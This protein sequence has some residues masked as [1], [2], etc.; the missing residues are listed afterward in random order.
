MGRSTGTVYY[1]LEF[2]LTLVEEQR[3]VFL[4]GPARIIALALQ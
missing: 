2:A 4:S 3:K 1:D